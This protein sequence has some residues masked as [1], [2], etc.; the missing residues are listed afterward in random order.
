MDTIVPVR[1]TLETMDTAEKKNR[2]AIHSYRDTML[3]INSTGVIEDDINLR[4]F[5][6]Q[7]ATVFQVVDSLADT[8]LR[9]RVR[10]DFEQRLADEE[11]DLQSRQALRGIDDIEFRHCVIAKSRHQID[12]A[13]LLSDLQQILPEEG[14]GDVIIDLYIATIDRLLIDI[15]DYIRDDVIRSLF[16]DLE[17]VLPESPTDDEWSTASIKLNRSIG[18][19]DEQMRYFGDL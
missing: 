3:R 13:G 6:I 12:I 1:A 4:G 7:M 14:G 17:E 18:K 15:D 10:N 16:S 9:E 19:L 11:I 5:V 2:S 8:M